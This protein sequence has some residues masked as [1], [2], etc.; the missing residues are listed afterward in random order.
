MKHCLSIGEA[1]ELS[2][3]F[4]FLPVLEKYIIITVRIMVNHVLLK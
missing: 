1:R 2:L 4:L 3:A